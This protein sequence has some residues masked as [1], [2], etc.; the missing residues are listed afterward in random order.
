[1]FAG[2]DPGSLLL[3]TL[4]AVAAT[5]VFW[6]TATKLLVISILVLIVFG[7]LEILQGLH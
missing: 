6:R 2:Q 1:M 5:V 4:V 3:V 7:F